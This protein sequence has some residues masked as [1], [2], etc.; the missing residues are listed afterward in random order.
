MDE[1]ITELLCQRDENRNL[2][3]AL[4][5]TKLLLCLAIAGLMVMTVGFLWAVSI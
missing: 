3:E 4:G 2:K 5:F 1:M